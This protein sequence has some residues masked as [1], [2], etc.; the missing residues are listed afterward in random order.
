M[1]QMPRRSVTR[2]FVPLIDVLL[3]LFCIFLLMPIAN[4]EQLDQQRQTVSELQDTVET[5]EK[6]LRRSKRE[7]A[8]VEALRADA[9][10]L[11]RLRDEVDKLRKSALKSLQERTAFHILDVDGKNGELSF[12][13]PTLPNPIVPVKDENAARELIEKHRQ[14]SA[15]RDLYYYF[16]YPR[17]TT[18]F[19]TLRQE[20]Q[21]KTWFKDI[22]NSLKEGA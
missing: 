22:A 10:E 18:G 6:D 19:P 12:Y 21:F 9:D 7:L 11:Q 3:L 16:L 13:D 1:I 8:D 15:G 4:E 5:L 2:F 14:K 17:P 20:R